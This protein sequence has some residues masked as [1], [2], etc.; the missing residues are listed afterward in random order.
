MNHM[1]GGDIAIHFCD[2]QVQSLISVPGT[3]SSTYYNSWRLWS[4]WLVCSV[5]MCV[6]LVATLIG[7]SLSPRVLHNSASLINSIWATET[8]LKSFQMCK[9]K[10]LESTYMR[11]Y[12]S[13]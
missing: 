2:L 9:K 10:F 3:S 5:R 11:G 1:I 6:Y 12:S 4:S 8:K 7:L 13:V